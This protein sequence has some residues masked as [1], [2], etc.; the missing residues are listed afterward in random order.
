MSYLVPVAPSNHFRHPELVSES[1]SQPHMVCVS[2]ARD[3]FSTVS[4]TSDETARW[5]LKQVQGD[6]VMGSVS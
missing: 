4:E 3:H 5:T 2:K 1:I 6:G